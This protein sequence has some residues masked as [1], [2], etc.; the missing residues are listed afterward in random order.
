MERSGI[1]H[2]DTMQ[3][4]GAALGI[5]FFSGLRLYATVLTLGL[6]V[7]FDW[8]PLTGE[9]ARLNVLGDTRIL[10]AAAVACLIEVIAD[11]VPWL[12][13]FWDSFHTFIRPLGAAALGWLAT[14]NMDPTIAVLV[15]IATGGVALTSHSSKA[16][17]RLAVNHSPEP[18]SN[19]IVSSVEDILAPVGIWFA[20]AHPLIMLG[21][22]AVF[23]AIF[24]WLAPRIYRFMRLEFAAL[25]SVLRSWFSSA[26]PVPAARSHER[27]L[28]VWPQLRS[29]FVPIDSPYADSGARAAATASIRGLKNSVGYLCIRD[30]ELLF[31]TRRMFRERLYSVPLELVRHAEWKRGL[32]VN[33]LVLHTN[34]GERHFYVFKAPARVPVGEAGR[35]PA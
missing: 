34:D 22:L 6:L 1:E 11:K 13:S 19:F 30:N 26:A 17:T 14:S 31:V 8:L 4:L 33:H 10:A 23:L 32:M 15:A 21:I 20:V 27:L 28:H 29:A 7:R 3:W 25:S 5:G 18:F 12:D 24:I 9:F 35:A 2:M 16:A